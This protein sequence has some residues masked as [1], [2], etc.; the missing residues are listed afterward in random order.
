M[1][2]LSHNLFTMI[3]TMAVLTT[4]AMPPMLRWALRR[5]PMGEGEKERVDREALDERG[6]VSR[7][8]RLLLAVDDSANG[9]FTAYLAGLVGGS[10]GMPTTVLR[11]EKDGADDS[12][13]RGEEKHLDQLKKGAKASASAVAEAENTSVDKVRLTARTESGAPGESIAEEGRKGYDLLFV[14]LGRSLTPKGAFTHKLNDITRGFNGPLCLVVRGPAKA[15]KAPALEPGATIL[16]PVNGTETARRA[17]DLALAIARPQRARVRALYVSPRGRNAGTGASLSHRREEA[18]LKDIADLAER[19]G[20]PIKTAM[21]AHG[22]A[23]EAITREAA[24]G[25]ALVVM[26][27]TQRSGDDL[28]FGDTAGAVLAGCA[29]PIVLVADERVRRDEAAKEAER[30]GKSESAS[31]AKETAA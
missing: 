27:V 2:I 30:S 11:L 25:V 31:T 29:V 10:S 18:A 22:A 15:E 23:A 3:V 20:V 21:K 28:F 1:N 17:A 14:G 19:Y 12:K 9:R 16:V 7:L 8:E 5:L 13:A 6:F 4:L 26:G 24:K